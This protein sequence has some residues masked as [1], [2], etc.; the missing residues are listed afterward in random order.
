MGRSPSVR[1][2][3]THG[4]PFFPAEVKR[5]WMIPIPNSARG[6][7]TGHFRIRIF[8]REWDY[9]AASVREGMDSFETVRIYFENR[10]AK[11]A[12]RLCSARRRERLSRGYGSQGVSSV[13]CSTVI[14]VYLHAP[15]SILHPPPNPPHLSSR[16]PDSDSRLHRRVVSILRFEMP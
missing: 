4:H 7:G 6:A 1:L 13:H 8:R 3:Q 14:H 2:Y 9:R 5:R 12:F 11:K 16:P 15:S 10:R